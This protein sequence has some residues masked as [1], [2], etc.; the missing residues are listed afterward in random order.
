MVVLPQSIKVVLDCVADRKPAGSIKV[1][2]PQLEA[3][4]DEN[5][6][7]DEDEQL[8]SAVNREATSRKY[9]SAEIA[10]FSLAAAADSGE[11]LA[12]VVP[13]LTNPIAE[14]LVAA[15]VAKLALDGAQWIVLAPC[16]LNNGTSLSRLD[17][18]GRFSEV[19]ALQP[20]H[21]ITGIG[22]AVVGELAQQ[23][24]LDSTSVLVLNA[25]GHPGYEKIDA[26]SIMDAVEVI[27]AQVVGSASRNSYIRK[28]SQG[29]RKI[30]SAATSGMY[31]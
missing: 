8:Y 17:V 1:E 3:E 21:F 2:Y 15:Q 6:E 13:H 9:Q 26:D 28:V 11:S 30:N 16:P 7:Y 18:G 14:K 4:N 19:P 23:K 29:V 12:L 10:V 5:E 27:G 31:I 25:E 22:A 24:R 20:P